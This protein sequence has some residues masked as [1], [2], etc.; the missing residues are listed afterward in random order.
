MGG[1]ALIDWLDLCAPLAHDADRAGPLYAG[2]VISTTA[3]GADIDWSIGKRLECEGSH[4]AKIQVRSSSMADGSQAI[5]ISGNP[6]KWFQGH[7]I[8]GSDDAHGLCIEMLTRVCASRG[9]TPTHEELTHWKNG[10]IDLLRVDVT[11]SYD[12]GSLPRVMN[13]LRSLDA[14]ANLRLRGRGSFNGNSLLFGKGSRHWSLTL[15]AKGMEILKHKLPAELSRS[16]LTSYAQGLLRSEVRMLSQH[17]KREG[18]NLAAAW[19]DNTAMEQHRL[20]MELLQISD[21][22][23]LD[24]EKLDALPTRLRAVYQLWKDGHD[25]RA[26]FPRN[27]FYRHRAGLLALGI[28]IAVKQERAPESN[29]VPLRVLLQAYPVDVPEWAQGTPLY[30]EP[31]RRFG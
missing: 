10:L 12:L 26:M 31:R 1:F 15:Y 22:V 16:S 25:L 28:D 21:A 11:R 30:F 20:H 18:L 6:A 4:S 27:T 13:A 19:Q 7:N 3:D 8:F 17:L 14:T 2:E 24:P 5:R 9:I 23:M 29:V